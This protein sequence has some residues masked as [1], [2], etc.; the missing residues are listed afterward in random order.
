MI[1]EYNECGAA[2][3]RE[4]GPASLCVTFR[5]SPISS[6]E[7]TSDLEARGAGTLTAAFGGLAHPPS[8]YHY[9]RSAIRMTCRVSGIRTGSAAT[10]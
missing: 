7:Q 6:R 3:Q 10:R 9:P 8:L 5:K 2:E 1:Y 4:P